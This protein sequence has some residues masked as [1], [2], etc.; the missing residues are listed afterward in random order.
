MLN[1]FQVCTPVDHVRINGF[2][3][4]LPI[5]I[6]SEQ[7]LDTII[8]ELFVALEATGSFRKQSRDDSAIKSAAYQVIRERAPTLTHRMVVEAIERWQAT[9]DS[10]T[11][12]AT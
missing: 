3:P 4:S 11:S 10:L 2:D 7:H 8:C 6:G 1:E 9:Q 12:Y 5:A